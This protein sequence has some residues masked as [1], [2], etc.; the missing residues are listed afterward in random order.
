MLVRHV[1]RDLHLPRCS[2]AIRGRDV[3]KQYGGVHGGS[4]GP[5]NMFSVVHALLY[6]KRVQGSQQKRVRSF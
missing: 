5:R 4:V 3:N 1:M 2:A 6:L